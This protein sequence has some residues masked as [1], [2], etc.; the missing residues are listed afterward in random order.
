MSARVTAF[1][2]DSQILAG[3]CR[4]DADQIVVSPIV[5]LRKQLGPSSL[6]VRL[7]PEFRVLQRRHL[8]FLDP[9]QDEQLLKR[10]VH[11]YSEHVEVAVDPNEGGFVLHPGQFA[12][13]ASL[14]YV[15]LPSSVGARIEG[16]SSWGRLGLEIHSTAGYIDP[17]FAGRITFELKNV[18]DVPIPLFVGLR[19]AQLAFFQGFPSFIP[20]A[21]KAENKYQYSMGAV[22]SYFFRDPEIRRYRE[23]LT[24]SRLR[25]I[26]KVIKRY[27]GPL[28][29]DSGE[30][31]RNLEIAIAE[32]M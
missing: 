6:D 10:R 24:S 11:S 12:L 2:T 29:V 14:E 9:F 20:Y 15:R 4:N 1:L 30:F 32:S 7:S 5:D 22:P 25:R 13:G 28:S 8:A 26:E 16:R 23:T 19:V 31:R 18:G 17:G 27:Y 3:L 21:N